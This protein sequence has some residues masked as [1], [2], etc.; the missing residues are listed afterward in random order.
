MTRVELPAA[1]R[2]VD[3]IV[4]GTSAGGIEAL[5]VLLPALPPG[6]PAPV[7]I[8]LHLPRELHFKNF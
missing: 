8:V 3:A 7:F 2:K 6:F 1:A 5:S 4:I